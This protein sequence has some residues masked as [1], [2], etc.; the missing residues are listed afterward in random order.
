MINQIETEVLERVIDLFLASLP[1]KLA[2]HFEIDGELYFVAENLQ[3]WDSQAS[4]I[5]IIECPE[6]R[7]CRL[8]LRNLQKIAHAA[9]SCG[10]RYFSISEDG[11]DGLIFQSFFECCPDANANN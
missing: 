1:E 5:L 11:D 7:V 4:M 6:R 2:Q 9:A 10:I 3:P 8:M